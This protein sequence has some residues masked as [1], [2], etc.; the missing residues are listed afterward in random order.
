MIHCKHN[1]MSSY[2]CKEHWHARKIGLQ[3][4]KFMPLHACREEMVHSEHTPIRER[5]PG[6]PSRELLK[7]E[8][9]KLLRMIATRTM[10]DG[11]PKLRGNGLVALHNA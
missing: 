6:G 4:M 1:G 10:K 5:F 7:T 2:T 8:E 3:G 11:R 9:G